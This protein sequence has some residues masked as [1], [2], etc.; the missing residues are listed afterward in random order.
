MSKVTM[1]GIP[2]CDTVKKAKNWLDTNG[3]EYEFVNFKKTPPTD[4]QLTIWLD[5]RGADVVVNKRGTTWRKL[6]EE[7]QTSISDSNALK[8]LLSE[9]PS[10]IK[11]PI[12]DI[13]DGNTTTVGFKA[14]IYEELFVS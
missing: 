5:R 8:Q 10:L 13:A 2:N 9:Q 3:I 11:R 6:N 1:Y 12:L 4:D 7:E 14:E